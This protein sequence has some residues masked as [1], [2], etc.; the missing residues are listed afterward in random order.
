MLAVFLS[1][2]L[3]SYAEVFI[4]TDGLVPCRTYV[5]AEVRRGG[6]NNEH[7]QGEFHIEC[8]TNC[9]PQN[10]RFAPQRAWKQVTP[11]EVS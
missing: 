2:Q 1:I 6:I 7:R 5:L 10:G 3:E 11:N 9:F 4:K 8:P